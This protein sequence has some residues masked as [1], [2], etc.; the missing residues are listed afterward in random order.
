RRFAGGRISFDSLRSAGV[1]IVCVG[2]AA[3]FFSSF[4]AAAVVTLLRGGRYELVWPARFF[5]HVLTELPLV[6]PL[7]MA[8]APHLPGTRRLARRRWV[9]AA[10]GWAALIAIG[11]IFATSDA[12]GGVGVMMVLAWVLPF[13]TWAALR[14]GPPGTSISVLIIALAAIAAGMRAEGPF[15]DA[16]S[17]Q[18]G[19]IALTVP[20]ICLPPLITDPH[21]ILP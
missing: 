20:L 11:S 7:M 2:L 8:F 1:F 9:E 17:L 3:P 21:P 13:T 4:L 12:L 14:L 10:A 15:D 19:L 5:S 6:P 16:L 18:I